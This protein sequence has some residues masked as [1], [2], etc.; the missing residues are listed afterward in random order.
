[1]VIKHYTAQEFREIS[2]LNA[3]WHEVE[4]DGSDIVVTVNDGDKINVRMFG[5]LGGSLKLKG[6]GDGCVH[7]N[8]IGRGNAYRMGKGD[9][10][11]YLDGVGEAYK[12]GKGMGN[13]Y[14][15]GV[16]APKKLA[17]RNGLLNDE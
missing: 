10:N 3:D 5:E 12:I 17:L 14:I 15:N 7:L 6:K 16:K 8:T 1:M 13:A 2:K 9:G 4:S 11:C